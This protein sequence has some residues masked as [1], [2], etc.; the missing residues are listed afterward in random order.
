M[1]PISKRKFLQISGSISIIGTSGCMNPI[2]DFSDS[3]LSNN[4]HQKAPIQSPSKPWSTLA[5][6]SKR[7]GSTSTFE[8][9]P[10]SASPKKLVPIGLF[11]SSQPA[12]TENFL[13]IGVDRQQHNENE[14]PFTG[15]V[16]YS[17]PLNQAKS[18]VVSKV[19]SET[20]LR[21]F[22]PTAQGQVVFAPTG[23][24]LTTF[25]ASNGEIYWTFP[26]GE[27]TPAV[28]GEDCVTSS[29]NRVVMLNAATGEKQW[30]S[31]KTNSKP[32]GVALLGDS[33]ILSCGS[34]G[35]GGLYCFDRS[36]GETRWFYDKIGESYAPPVYGGNHIYGVGTDGNVHAIGLTDGK[37]RWKY[38]TGGDSY[39]Q[40]STIDGLVYT[41]ST[42]SDKIAALDGESGETIWERYIGVGGASPPAVTPGEVIYTV[43]SQS[44]NVLTI[45]NRSTGEIIRRYELYQIDQ[46]WIQPALTSDT[47]YLVGTPSNQ[48]QSML[49]ALQ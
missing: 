30:E 33:I 19:S 37:Q 2:Q 45:L 40:A 6:N 42:S 20:P 25:N 24:R 1:V 34:S 15:A 23:D 49:Y 21:S 44:G 9:P 12:I 29:N 43:S 7:T 3:R 41:T 14:E 5:G 16:S 48:K 32:S 38:F 13:H 4:F 27:I 39:G 26:G 28:D 35:D 11:P 17:R 22:T 47:I 46:K 36:T 18:H 8:I 10:E 31:E